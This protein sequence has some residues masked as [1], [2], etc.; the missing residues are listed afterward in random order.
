MEET[1]DAILFLR[2]QLQQNKHLLA[3]LAGRAP[4]AG[5]VPSFTLEEFTL[6]ADYPLVVPS[7]LVRARPDIQA[8]GPAA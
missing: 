1:R 6:P 3:V 8:A 5:S 7:E 4:G 2:N